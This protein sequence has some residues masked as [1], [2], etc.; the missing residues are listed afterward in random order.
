MKGLPGRAG[1]CWGHKGEHTHYKLQDTP[2][3]KILKSWV[4]DDAEYY[5]QVIET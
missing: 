1:I 5:L 4:G 3:R 2:D